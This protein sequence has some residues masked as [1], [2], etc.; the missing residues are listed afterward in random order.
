MTLSPISRLIQLLKLEKHDLKIL[1]VLI[2]GYGLI[3]IATP[4]SVQ[5]LVNIV[6]MGSVLQPLFIVSLILFLLLLLS[7]ALYIFES[8]IVELI[9]RRIFI[10]TAIQTSQNARGVEISLYDRENPVELINRFFDVSTVQKSAATLLTMGLTSLLQILIGSLILIFYSAFFSLFIFVIIGF[11]FFI[12]RSLGRHATETAIKESKAKFEMASWLENIAKNIFA[13]KFYQGEDRAAKQT[14]QHVHQYIQT[15]TKHF[16]ILLWQNISVALMY[17]IAGTGLL[18]L[19][20][21]L[22]IQGEI[23]LGQFVAAE[24]IIF[25]VL[26]AMVRL[27]NKLDYF[28]DL[29][30][31]LDKIGVLQDIP[32]EHSGVHDLDQLAL[33]T[34]KV[35][36]VDFAYNPYIQPLKNIH[37]EL[38]KGESLAVLG[39]PGTG[40]STLIKLIAKLRTPSA[41][42]ISINQLDLRQ[43]DNNAVRN[44][45]GL[46]GNI[47]IGHGTILENICLGREIPLHKINMMIEE[48]GLAD[49]F[50]RF[51][52]G[53]ET[54]I[55]ASGSP[56]SS[57]QLQ[58]LM[59]ARASIASPKILLIDGLLD[60]FNSAELDAVMIMFK[61]HE[62]E[63]V[64]IVTTR[65]EHIAKH[66]DKIL[67]LNE[68]EHHH[69]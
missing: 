58:R 20:G 34:L 26:T 24:L 28:Y 1:P 32:Q 3:S 65:F 68:V 43:L 13:C 60:S 19:G 29:L 55:T 69:E 21:S 45:M 50:H 64:L 16:N 49:D 51:P 40:K 48:L 14:H 54:P 10:R 38:K 42:H 52:A 66:F 31:A 4:V 67:N 12:V 9:Q 37:F 18:A 23:N 27:V 33:N 56:L 61:Q 44:I 22:V 46:A 59:I 62:D 11:L 35:V 15:R 25:G 5:A 41:G 2:F 53:I 30:A 8:Y 6:T 39:D 36:G 7:G 47:E 63:W 57:N 17:A